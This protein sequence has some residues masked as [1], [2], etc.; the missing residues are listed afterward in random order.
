VTPLLILVY[1]APSLVLIDNSPNDNCPTVG[2]APA[3]EDRLWRIVDAITQ[4]RA[5]SARCIVVAFYQSV[6]RLGRTGV[7]TDRSESNSVLV[8][9]CHSV[10]MFFLAFHSSFKSI[11]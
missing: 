8:L 3:Y 2:T 1:N 5:D 11:D 9:S 10:S 6:A 4:M 7:V